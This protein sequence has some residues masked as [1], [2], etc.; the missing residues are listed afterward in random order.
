MCSLYTTSKSFRWFTILFVQNFALNPQIVK[1][2][3]EKKNWSFPKMH[4]LQHLFTDTQRKGTCENFNCAFDGSFHQGLIAAYERTNK[5]NVAGKVSSSHHPH[6]IH[7][8]DLICIDPVDRDPHDCSQSD[9]VAESNSSKTDEQLEGE[10]VAI[11]ERGANG[12]LRPVEKGVWNG[13]RIGG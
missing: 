7:T 3:F 11:S 9:P 1:P 10:E 5:K 4:Q 2:L 12:P 6:S 13:L 8:T